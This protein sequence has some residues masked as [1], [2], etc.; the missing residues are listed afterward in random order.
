[1]FVFPMITD[2]P[3][4]FGVISFLGFVDPT[5]IFVLSND[6]LFYSTLCFLSSLNFRKWCLLGKHRVYYLGKVTL[7]EPPNQY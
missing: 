5:K 6:I 2:L 4:V 1:M 7:A 3:L